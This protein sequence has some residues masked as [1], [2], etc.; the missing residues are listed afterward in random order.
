MDLLAVLRGIDACL[1]LAL[2]FLPEIGARRREGVIR[3]SIRYGLRVIEI[4]AEGNGRGLAAR[5]PELETRM[6]SL[7]E[8]TLGCGGRFDRIARPGVGG[9][10]SLELRIARER[11]RLYRATLKHERPVDLQFEVAPR[12]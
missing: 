11:S 3:L 5:N 6:N 12:G 10:T 9:R 4:A 8:S 7:R 1:D 2:E